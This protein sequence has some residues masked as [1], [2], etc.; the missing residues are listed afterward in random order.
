MPP[1]ELQC[2]NHCCI[3]SLAWA[4]TGHTFQGQI[5][6]QDCTVLCIINQPENKTMEGLCPGILYMF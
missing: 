5:T 2:E 3:L 6:R 4:K 1:L